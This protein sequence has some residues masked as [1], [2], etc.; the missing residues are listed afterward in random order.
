MSADNL[1]TMLETIPS[2]GE[3]EEQS[4]DDDEIMHDADLFDIA[5]L[6][7]IF[8]DQLPTVDHTEDIISDNEALWD[9]EDNIPL[10][11]LRQR[12]LAKNTTWTQSMEYCVTNFK[13]FT[14]E[15]GPKIPNDLER[16][17]D[18]FLH[19]FPKTLIDKIVFE[20][21][22]YALQ[23]R[24]GDSSFTPTSA[25]EIETF[26][27]INI[28][29]G[30]KKLPS[31]CDYW[32][33]REQLR[34][35]YISSA[36]SRDRFAWLLANVHFAD[37]SVMPGRDS[38]DYDKLYKVRVLL[39]TLSETFRSSYGPS[40]YQSIDESMIR[41]KG[42]SFLKQFMP[43]KPIKRG[44]KVWV[45]SDEKG[46]VCQFQIYVGKTNNQPEKD[47]GK[48]VVLDLT[49]DLVGKGYHVYFDNFFNS[50]PLQK[51]LQAEYSYACGT[52]RANRQHLPSDLQSD[53]ELQTRGQS[54]SRVSKDGLAFIKWR[55]RKIVHFLGNHQNPSNEATVI[56]KQKDG[57]SQVVACPTMV[58]EYNQHMGYVDKTDMLKSVYEIDRKSKKWWHRIMWHFIDICVVNSFIL[59]EQKAKCAVPNL[60]FFRLSVASGLIGISGKA[61][62]RSRV[63][64]PTVTGRH[65]KQIVPYEKRFEQCLHMPTHGTSRRC[66]F[67]S[68][69]REPHRTR[70]EC[71]TCKVGLCLTE[72]KNCFSLYHKK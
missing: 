71:A 8:E 27:G 58:K 47:L 31:Y 65:F 66:A 38:P 5:N 70:W 1:F 19:L 11:I 45:R 42:R 25:K 67:C 41:F 10:S 37:N 34:D 62:S 40:K 20:T 22:L 26:I 61:N 24:G 64:S 72:K 68:T 36:M 9:E 60:K 49:R 52:V 15:T 2:D 39:D 14:E 35:H 13:E 54:D 33:A 56:R 18:V 29:M 50:V 43:L 32:S 57:N 16:P 4:S 44:Y 46:Y 12:E 30:I 53:K 6:P 21:N 48:R 51:T 23:K 63:S 28:L 3:S 69:S 17:V 7:I 59:F 55:D